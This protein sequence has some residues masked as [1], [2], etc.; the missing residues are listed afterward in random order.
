MTS[1]M[2]FWETLDCGI[3]VDATLTRTTH[4]NIVVV[5]PFITMVFTDG[6][7]LFQQAKGPCHT[8][9]TAQEWLYQTQISPDPN[10]IEH[11]QDATEQAWSNEAQ[12]F[13]C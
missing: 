8:A 12:R 1:A 9:N 7:G 3:N 4:S 6:S 5:H 11:P 13:R 10:S 2:F